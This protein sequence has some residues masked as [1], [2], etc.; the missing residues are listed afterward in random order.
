MKNL[1]T[2]IIAFMFVVLFSLYR[3][4]AVW[5]LWG[6]FGQPLFPTLILSYLEIVG[7]LLTIAAV[8][9]R[10]TYVPQEEHLKVLKHAVLMP[11][12]L[13]TVGFIIKMFM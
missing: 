12:T 7:L 4:W 13:V 10:W 1:N 5:I 6:W 8:R 9:S 11:I 2:V 3:A